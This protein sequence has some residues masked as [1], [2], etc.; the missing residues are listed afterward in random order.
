MRE[1]DSR[2]HSCN[3]F[4]LFI[5]RKYT[6]YD[7]KKSTFAHFLTDEQVII[8]KG[9]ETKE[10]EAN[11]VKIKITNAKREIIYNAARS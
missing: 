5:C 4:T 6:K 2:D 1:G 7:E 11:L 10:D 8:K 9:K 3:R